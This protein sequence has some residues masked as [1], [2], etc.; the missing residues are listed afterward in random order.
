MPSAPWPYGVLAGS[1]GAPSAG[2]GADAGSVFGIG[3]LS[4][5][6]QVNTFRFVR[7]GG[8]YRGVLTIG[9]V[10]GEVLFELKMGRNSSYQFSSFQPIWSNL[11][12][13]F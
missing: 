1:Q 12:I 11:C 4:F 5:K 10:A 3:D 6:Y 7:S 9:R 2:A 8:H 13:E